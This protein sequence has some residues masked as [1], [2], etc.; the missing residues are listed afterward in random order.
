[1]RQ[2]WHWQPSAAG[3][4]REIICWHLEPQSMCAAQGERLSDGGTG[5]LIGAQGRV[6]YPGWIYEFSSLL[7]KV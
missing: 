6:N 7:L 2:P 4:G 5:T 3:D 1:M